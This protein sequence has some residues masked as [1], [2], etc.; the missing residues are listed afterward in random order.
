[1]RGLAL[2]IDADTWRGT[3][4]GVPAIARLLE[5]LGLPATFLFSLGPDATGRALRRVFRPGFLGKVRRTSV[6][7]HYGIRTL[8]YGT[9]LPSPDIGRREGATM[10]AVAS[11]GF[12]TG[13]HA[14]DHTC[15]QDG[16]IGASPAWTDQQMRLSA[17]RYEDVFG[18]PAEIHGAAGWQMNDAACRI[19]QELGIRVASDTRG[20]SPFFPVNSAGQVIGPLQIPTTLPTMDELIGVDGCKEDDVPSRLLALTEQ[21]SGLQVFTLHAELEGQLL[22]GQFRAVLAGWLAQGWTFVGMSGLP[23]LA[24]EVTDRCTIVPGTVPGRSGYVSVQGSAV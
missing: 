15:W 1:M 16:V 5:G 14:W 23:G 12:D 3:R 19:E 24:D 22:I 2:K 20:T 4:E 8:L 17:R 13:I 18:R 6:A 7:R 9:L 11:A 10:R 21:R